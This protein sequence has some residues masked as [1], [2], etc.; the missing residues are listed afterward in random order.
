MTF[1]PD[2]TAEQVLAD[3]DLSGTVA[4]VTGASSGLGEGVARALAGRGADVVAAVRDTAR[5]SSSVVSVPLDLASLGSVRAAAEQLR[6]DLPR[7]DLLFNNAGIMA[8]PEGRTAEGFEMQLGT[9]HLGH[10]LLTALLSGVIAA[11]GRIVNTSSLAHVMTGMQWDDPQFRHRPYE[12]WRAYGQ[13]KTAN[14]LF[15]RGLADR[16]FTAYAVHPGSVGTELTRHL[17]AE[18]RAFVSERSVSPKTVEE[19]VAT[20]VWAAIADD[21]ASGAYLADC[22]VAEAAPHATDPAEVDRLWSWSEEQV[23]QEFRGLTS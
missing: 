21:I 7:I 14:V 12:K 17:D 22:S 15:T 18:E 16:G 19:G 13:S 3:V 8:A 5:V 10:F 20:L 9:N 1:G 23:G 6:S 11:D 4:V 2:T